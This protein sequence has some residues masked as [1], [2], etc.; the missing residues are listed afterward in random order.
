M[1]FRGCDLVRETQLLWYFVYR[2]GW[3]LVRCSF[4]V[5]AFFVLN[6][7]LNF[8][9]SYKVGLGSR[10]GWLISADLRKMKK[11]EV[12]VDG[13]SITAGGGCQ[14]VDLETT[15]QGSYFLLL[16]LIAALCL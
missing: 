13:M 1:G 3:L 4:F 5:Y 14:A 11:V 6:F 2:E 15:L 10:K 7:S 12:D 9:Y 16:F 8:L